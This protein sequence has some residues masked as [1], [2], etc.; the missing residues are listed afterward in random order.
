MYTICV[1]ENLAG[2]WAIHWLWTGCSEIEESGSPKRKMGDL[3]PL[4][5]NIRM[6]RHPICVHLTP[7]TD[8]LGKGA[9]DSVMNFCKLTKD[10]VNPGKILVIRLL[11][12]SGLMTSNLLVHLNNLQGDVCAQWPWLNQ[13][14]RTMWDGAFPRYE[15]IHWLWWPSSTNHCVDCFILR[16]IKLWAFIRISHFHSPDKVGLKSSP[17]CSPYTT[18]PSCYFIIITNSFIALFHSA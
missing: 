16:L 5:S 6:Q 15:Q 18:E 9:H 11:I 3:K 13:C 7:H 8:K 1:I 14:L 10:P 12:Q 4:I 2:E 17:I